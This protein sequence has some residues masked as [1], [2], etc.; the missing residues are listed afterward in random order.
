LKARAITAAASTVR[1]G[2]RVDPMTV[3]IPTTTAT[4][5]AVKKAASTPYTT[6]LLMTTSISYMR[7]FS[8]DADRDPQ[9]PER[10]SPKDREDGRRARRE[11]RRQKRDHDEHRS[12]R[13]SLQLQSL[14]PSGPP[15]AN[16]NGHERCHD[17]ADEREEEDESDRA[18]RLRLC[19][20][21][22]P[23]FRGVDDAEDPHQREAHDRAPGHRVPST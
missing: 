3:P 23:H 20:R 7:Y 5:T 13:E 12:R 14:V 2:L 22:P 6:V 8:T 11:D 18:T 17:R 21:M 9:K 10:Q 15:E 19:E 1:T 16:Q 4:Y